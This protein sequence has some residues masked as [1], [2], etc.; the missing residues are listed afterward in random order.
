MRRDQSVLPLL[1]PFLLQCL[2][3]FVH[4][5]E[6]MYGAA[7]VALQLLNGHP[8]DL[9]RLGSPGLLKALPEP[10]LKR[11]ELPVEPEEFPGVIPLRMFQKSL[12]PEREI[13]QLLL[14]E[15]H[16]LRQ[17][18]HVPTAAP[19]LVHPVQDL[20][21]PEHLELHVFAHFCRPARLSV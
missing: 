3:L 17:D 13:V 12:G 10:F 4:P 14:T 5:P 11:S 8:A 9:G 18:S 1:N 20:L 19:P 16:R 21:S 6:G 15:V 2:L 7:R